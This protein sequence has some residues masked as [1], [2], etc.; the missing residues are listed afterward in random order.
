LIGILD[1]C[2]NKSWENDNI[3]INKCETEE[4]IEYINKR[5]LFRYYGYTPEEI[6]GKD[7]KDFINPNFLE[8]YGLN[9]KKLFKREKG[10]IELELRHK[11]NYYCP[12]EVS[13]SIFIDMNNKP[14]Q[15]IFIRDITGRKRAEQQLKESEEKYRL[16]SEDADDLI[17]LYD[18]HFRIFKLII[19]H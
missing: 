8:S 10:F 5:P 15:L 3:Y 11:K 14:K 1:K 12:V 9:I 18:E 13:V 7:I 6:I 17:S 4:I 2:I 19:Y 16:I